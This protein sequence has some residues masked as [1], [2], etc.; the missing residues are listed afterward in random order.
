MKLLLKCPQPMT[1]AVNQAHPEL[2]PSK[3]ISDADFW[4]GIEELDDLMRTVADRNQRLTIK[5]RYG[6]KE[7]PS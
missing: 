2:D 3:P 1:K 6:K 5:M 7:K 4:K